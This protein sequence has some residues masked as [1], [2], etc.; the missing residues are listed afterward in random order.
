VGQLAHLAEV[1]DLLGG[2]SSNDQ[3]LVGSGSLQQDV[4]NIQVRTADL[5]VRLDGQH[6]LQQMLV[7]IIH[8]LDVFGL[9]LVCEHLQ[10]VLLASHFQ[11]SLILCSV[12]MALPPV[13]P[14][15]WLFDLFGDYVEHRTRELWTGKIIA[16]AG[17][18]ELTERAIRSALL[19]LQRDGWLTV[20]RAGAYSF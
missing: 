8:L 2:R 3:L 13:K 6:A 14:R 11:R 1:V 4:L 20:R 12:A 9:N 7:F 15:S 19:R 16:L 17:E 10:I 18:F 5:A